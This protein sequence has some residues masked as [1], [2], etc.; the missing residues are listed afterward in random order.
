MTLPSPF[1]PARSAATWSELYD[2]LA[3]DEQ[4]FF[5]FLEKELQKVESFFLARQEEAVKRAKQ[6]RAQLN[7]LA[8]HRRLY[9][10]AYPGNLPKWE[11][12][13]ERFLP[14]GAAAAHATVTGVATAAQKLQQRL[15][16]VGRESYGEHGRGGATDGVSDGQKRSEISERD[17]KQ[18]SAD[19]YTKYKHEL[20]KA[21]L[22]FYRNLEIIKNYRVSFDIDLPSH[23]ME[24]E[25]AD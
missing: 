12:K 21:T 15:P 1:I 3:P 25:Y 23:G 10:E 18:F 4:E 13:V 2:C 24:R 19:R 20:R 17:R 9:H 11:S 14:A 16:I 22:E 5:D 8:E 7:E 6:L